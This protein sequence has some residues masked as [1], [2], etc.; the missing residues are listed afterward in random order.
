MN[1]SVIILAV[2]LSLTVSSC[3][4]LKKKPNR[5]NVTVETTA[6]SSSINI[7]AT[8]S[9]TL[10]EILEEPA[11]A[12]PVV[13]EEAVAP[14]LSSEK[15]ELVNILMPL[16]QRRMDYKTFKGKAKMHYEGSGMQHD[17]TANFRIAKDSVIWVHLTAGMGLVNVAR[18]LITPDSLTLVSYLDKSVLRLTAEEAREKLPAAVDFRLL[19]SLVLGEALSGGGQAIDASDFGGTW[20]INVADKEAK[21]QVNFNKADSTMRSLQVLSDLGGGLA[22]VIQFGNYQK[23]NEKVFALSRA[24]NAQNK[25]EQ[26]YLDMTFNN[27]SFDETLDFPF[28]IPADYVNK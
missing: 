2:L 4:L 8:D 16:L 18:L 26:H 11:A 17:F 13:A 10:L 5:K 27:A 21:Q 22:G 28:S 14:V 7:A 1:K 25:G 20:S 12:E 15:Q 19:Q 9:A 24:I 23:V 3:N 6:D